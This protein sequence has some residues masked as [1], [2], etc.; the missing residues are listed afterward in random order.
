MAK[1]DA[2]ALKA[3]GEKG[4]AFK[5]ADGSFSY[6][7][8]DAEDLA[9]AIDAVGGGNAA[10]ED[11]RVYV[12]KRANTLGLKDRIPDTWNTDGTL[13]DDGRSEEWLPVVPC[14]RTFTIDDI[15]IRAGGDGRV[16][17]AYA[18][19]FGAP[20]EITDQDGHYTETVDPAAF[21]KTLGDRAGQIGVFYNHGRTLHGTPSER[22]SMPL[23]TPEEIRADSRGLLTVTRYN[24]NPL[25]DE[26]LESI[27]NGDITGQSFSGKFITS[28]RTRA[29]SYGDLDTIHRSEIALREYGPTP[30]PAYKEAR[31]L[32]VRTGELVDSFRALD[33]EDQDKVFAQI[34]ASRT[35]RTTT[36]DAGHTTSTSTPPPV[37]HEGPSK[38]QRQR[39]A[40]V[41]ALQTL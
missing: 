14:E 10:H 33:V 8:A 20:A 2:D 37:S 40:R 22:F 27:R 35:D 5:N 21:N 32:G 34:E 41:L 19:I 24:K 25:A 13:K 36:T 6:P 9:N 15:S 23:G 28:K 18:A 31:V 4:D 16:V 12:M 17:T 38:E 29:R 1:Y 11:L 7:I 30:M 26:V 3:L 39:R